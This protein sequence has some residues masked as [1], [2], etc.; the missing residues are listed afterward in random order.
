[1]LK[2]VQLAAAESGGGGGNAVKSDTV[3]GELPVP[4][5]LYS[6]VNEALT[7][8]KGKNYR[9]AEELLR[10]LL[11][12]KK[13]NLAAI[14]GLGLVF[15]M[16]GEDKDHPFGDA[17]GKF[18]ESSRF[19]RKALELKPEAKVVEMVSVAI[20]RNNLQIKAYGG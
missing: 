18:L 12:E 6:G 16:W 15:Q 1:M 2:L 10:G 7:C 4:M 5:E 13:D 8:A 14:V 17:K 19:F 3:E 20:A 9:R 11:G